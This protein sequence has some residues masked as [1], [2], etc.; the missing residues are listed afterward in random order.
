MLAITPV[1][2]LM[3]RFNNPDALLVMLL[4]ASA[5]CMVRA[6]EDARTRWLVATG[7][8]VG[9]AFLTKMGQALLVVP[10]FGLAYLIC[11]P[12][13]LRRRIAGL[14]AGLGA[15]VVS[16]RL[17]GR[18]R[19][20]AAGRLA[21]DDRRLARQQHLQPDLRLQRPQ[22]P[23]R[24]RRARRAAAGGGANFSGTA[25]TLRL[26]NDLMG[27][28]A[29]WLL[30]AA[31]VA[32]VALAWQRRGDA[33]H[34]PHA[35]RAAPLGRLAAGDRGRVQLLAG[36]HPHLLRGRAGAGDRRARRDR[37][38]AAVG[39]ARRRSRRASSRR[40]SSALTG[41][42]SFALLD[43]TPSWKPWLR[44]L[45]LAAT[46]VAVAGLL[47]APLLGRRARAVGVAALAAAL[48]A[49]FAGEFAY[50]LQTISTAHTGSIPSAGPAASTAGVGGPGGGAAGGRL[51]PQSSARARAS[52]RRRARAR[53]RASGRRRARAPPR[54]AA[55]GSS[56]APAGS[57]RVS[58]ARRLGGG[59][60]GGWR[61]GQRPAA[62][63]SVRSSP[64]RAATAGSRRP[65]ARRARRA[66]SSR[67]AAIR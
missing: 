10:G 49:C 4:V 11:A 6:L 64:G 39:R 12:T 55:A 17:V 20:A 18:D 25:G 7:A 27:G 58:D 36:R 33:A 59:G 2:A 52:G 48:V 51:G 28:Q 41:A 24:W 14:A 57:G 13:S 50:T 15:L 3:F 46:I 45:V 67:R 66:T 5:Y 16:A 32:L 37:R 19:R 63:S 31:L 26:F 38:A 42:W 43:R 22:P 35:R 34:R 62:R 54:A 9:F 8:L 29:S 60:A 53:A 65:T 61:H 30:P 44:A 40:R 1:A 23:L 21:A 56:A 47:F